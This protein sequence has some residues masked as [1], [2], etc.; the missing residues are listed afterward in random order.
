M[1]GATFGPGAPAVP[2]NST[3]ERPGAPTSCDGPRPDEGM[4]PAGH[5][6]GAGLVITD[7]T[8]TVL[9]SLP[10]VPFAVYVRVF[11]NITLWMHYD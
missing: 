10:R 2:K 5:N 11:K 1:D 6:G 3:Q 8:P 7:E 4:L 9:P